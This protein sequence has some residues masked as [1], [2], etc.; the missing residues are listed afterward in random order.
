MYTTMDR[1]S[2]V[3]VT[4]RSIQPGD[5]TGV[6]E[7]L[8]LVFGGWP[9]LDLN[10][11]P[12]EYWRWKYE[13]KIDLGKFVFVAE[14]DDGEPVGCLHVIPVEF[15]GVHGVERCAI[16]VDY[17]V[18]PDYR[19]QGISSMLS[20]AINRSLFEAGFMFSYSITSHPRVISRAIKSNLCFNG[21]ILN[22]VRV[23]DVDRQLEAMPMKRGWVVKAG[24]EVLRGFNRV[25][26]SLGPKVSRGRVSVVEDTGFGVEAD[27]LWE[28]VSP[29]YGFMLKRDSGYLN[30]RY[31]DPRLGGFQVRKAYEGDV[32]LG[33]CVFRVNRFREEYP[34]GYVLDLVAVP[35]RVDVACSLLG[36]AV[37]CFDE[38]GVNVVNVMVMEGAW[39]VDALRLNGFLDSRVR[40]NVYLDPLGEADR[41]RELLDVEPGRVLVSWGDHDAMPVRAP[42]VL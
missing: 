3:G 25:R 14:T 32:F 19:G 37:R 29:Y 18:H 39:F 5:E 30:W 13:G 17:A 35:G 1:L 26:N 42:E 28:R 21:R 15:K 36:E 34:V 33:Y 6:V 9:H 8:E 22:Y 4:V 24:Y 11:S 31:C 40:L 27:E 10:C 41:V 20:K 23:V 16:G 7:L 2:A 12:L 38:A